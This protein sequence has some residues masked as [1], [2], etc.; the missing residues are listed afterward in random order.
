MKKIII[1]LVLPILLWQCTDVK[2]W[3]DPEDSIAPGVVSNVRVENINGGATIHYN[4]PNDNDL[5]GVKAVFSFKD[6]ES[7]EVFSSAF[8]DSILVEGAPDTNEYSVNLYV[9]DKSHNESAPVQASIKPLT[10]PVETVRRSL[11]MNPT[12]GGIYISWE[13][14][15]ESD[16]AISLYKKDSLGDFVLYD[17]YYSKTSSGYFAFRGLT[18]TPQDFRFEIRDKWRNYSTPLDTVLTPLFEEEIFGRD[19]Y[20]GVDIWQ[21]YGW[22][23]TSV[24]RGDITNQQSGNNYAFRVIHDGSRWDNTYYW[25]SSDFGNNLAQYI[26][27]PNTTD[28]VYPIYFT[29]DM[30]RSASYSRL[31]YWMRSRSPIFSAATFTSLEVWATKEPKP[32]ATVGDGSKE[33][34][35]KYWTQWPQVGGTDEWK[36]DWVKIADYVLKFPSGIAADVANANLLTTEDK[37]FVSSGFEVEVDPAYSDQTFRYIRFLIRENNT[38]VAQ[39]QLSELQFWGAYAE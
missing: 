11:R 25:H 10:P 27:W 17:T 23:E 26:S 32:I 28:M 38:P 1:L 15:A 5:L 19:Q 30:G 24:Y 35:L 36:N 7:R 22:P 34:N 12:F 33:D 20:T 29:I 2:D 39:I 31:K 16:I 6:D 37:A 21:R 13:N 14:V 4:L 8:N 18:N 9:L 3:H